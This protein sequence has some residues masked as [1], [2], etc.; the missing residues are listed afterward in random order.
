MQ[1]HRH[2]NVVR[3]VGNDDCGRLGHGVD[4]KRICIDHRQ[5]SNPL[6][7]P[8]GDRRRQLRRKQVIDLDRDH[9]A[10]GLEQAEGQRPQ[11]WPNLEDDVVLGELGYG[12]DSSYGVGVCDEVLSA[13]LA[14]PQSQPAG[15]LTYGTG[16]EQ[17][18]HHRAS[19]TPASQ[20]TR[21]TLPNRRRLG[22][23]W[24]CESAPRGSLRAA[25]P[26]RRTRA[27]C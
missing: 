15:Q 12:N 5:R 4:P 24:L 19:A 18:T 16:I 1:Q 14:R 17:P 10:G 9:P 27:R 8:L 3:K 22:P 25:C 13:L 6:R 7:Q 23:S 2:S 20:C 11:S 26:S 21:A